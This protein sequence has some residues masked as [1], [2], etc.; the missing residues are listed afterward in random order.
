MGLAGNAAEVNEPPDANIL[1]GVM[2]YKV[3]LGF[4]QKF[5]AELNTLER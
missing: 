5:H 3:R 2:W 1:G 4:Q